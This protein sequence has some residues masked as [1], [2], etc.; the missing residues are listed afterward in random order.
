MYPEDVFAWAMHIQ[1]F[2]ACPERQSQDC[3][4]ES[5]AQ[6][7]P[8]EEKPAQARG[9]PAGLLLTRVLCARCLVFGEGLN[10]LQG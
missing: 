9:N 5:Q 1:A 10:Q 3:S 8:L 7:P 2:A 6:T 4:I